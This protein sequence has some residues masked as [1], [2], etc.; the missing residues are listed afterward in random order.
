MPKP[1]CNA[2]RNGWSGLRALTA[3]QSMPAAR[4]DWQSEYDFKFSFNSTLNKIFSKSRY[5]TNF[6]IWFSTRES[7]T[8]IFV[9]QLNEN[10]SNS[11]RRIRVFQLEDFEPLDL[12]YCS[13]KLQSPLY[14]TLL[15]FSDP[16]KQNENTCISAGWELWAIRL[17]LLPLLAQ[18]SYK[19]K[20][21]HGLFT[22]G[23]Q[24]CSVPVQ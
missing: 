18:Q 22:K 1:V 21:K 16:R 23:C 10:M 2:K 12:L 19:V 4:I 8:R 9:F 13:T 3:V 24:E 15:Y 5:Y 11:W 6:R 7:R 14:F 17:A 20:T